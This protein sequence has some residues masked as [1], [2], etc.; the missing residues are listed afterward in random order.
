MNAHFKLGRLAP[1]AEQRARAPQLSRYMLAPL[2]PPPTSCFNSPGAL[3]A[4]WGNDR[5][6]DC[7][8]AALANFRAI[9][10]AK[11]GFPFPTTESDVVK[12]YLRLG[13]GQ[14]NGLVEHDVLEAATRGLALG[15]PESWRLAAWV[16]V[17]IAD[18]ETCRRLV[19][20]LWGLYLG[21]A[22]PLTAQDQA[23]WD[24]DSDL[25]GDAAPGSWGG[26]AMWWADFDED[27]TLGLVTWGRVQKATPAW[28]ATYCDEAYALLDEDRAR[29]I[30]V[31][32][33]ALM[34]DLQAGGA[35][36][37]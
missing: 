15:G 16:K 28:L 35:S 11:E 6:G 32:W 17:D 2:P 29:A 8:V 23:F 34:R 18:R 33:D 22:M 5:Y 20:D 13:G 31:D 3:I 9:C 24:V 27:G 1:S 12:E 4:M 21:C 10:A 37:V 19:A 26:H 30:G 36:W 25:S 7:T 14:D